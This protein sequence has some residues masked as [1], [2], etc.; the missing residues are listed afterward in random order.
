MLVV[1]FAAS[2]YSIDICVSSNPKYICPSDTLTISSIKKIDDILK[3]LSFNYN[4]D[5]HI[6]IFIENTHETPIFLNLDEFKLNALTAT[7]KGKKESSFAVIDFCGQ[8]YDDKSVFSYEGVTIHPENTSGFSIGCIYTKN[9]DFQ[10]PG[11]DSGKIYSKH[12]NEKMVPK[13][14]ISYNGSGDYTVIEFPLYPQLSKALISRQR[15]IFMSN[16]DQGTITIGNLHKGTVFIDQ[17]EKN[18]S[19]PFTVFTDVT[20]EVDLPFMCLKV[21]QPTKIFLGKFP[22]QPS[23]IPPFGVNIQT[24]DEVTINGVS[25]ADSKFV[26]FDTEPLKKK[27]LN[28]KHADICPYH[29]GEDE[30][31]KLSFIF[32]NLTIDYGSIIKIAKSSISIQADQ[33]QSIGYS[34]RQVDEFKTFDNKICFWNILFTIS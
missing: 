22:K 25:A 12:L 1:L 10:F 6:N 27:T 24:L 7:L 30:S 13:S 15:V 18:H 29:Y 11:F 23:G 3:I 28:V 8:V 16:N 2:S 33:V 26:L 20:D 9:V 32:K 21:V 5:R 34:F 19:E 4:E 17:T 31:D 14:I